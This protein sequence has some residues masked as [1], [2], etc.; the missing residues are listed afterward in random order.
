MGFEEFEKC[1]GLAVRRSQMEVGN[2]DGAETPFSVAVVV[3]CCSRVARV[4]LRRWKLVCRLAHSESRAPGHSTGGQGIPS[5]A[6]QAPRKCL[7]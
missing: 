3:G 2:E 4:E 7:R 6:H 5:R 1:F